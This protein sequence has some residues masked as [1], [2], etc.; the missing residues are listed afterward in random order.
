MV[1][2]VGYTDGAPDTPSDNRNRL[3]VTA[4]QP[5]NMRAFVHAQGIGELTSALSFTS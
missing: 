2:P 4:T 1:V 3:P 5:A